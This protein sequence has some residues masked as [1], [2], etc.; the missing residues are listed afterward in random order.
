MYVRTYYYAILFHVIN[1]CTYLFE[2][3]AHD[4]AREERDDGSNLNRKMKFHPLLTINE[5]RLS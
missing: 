3:R 5:N 2:S 4:A 1:V